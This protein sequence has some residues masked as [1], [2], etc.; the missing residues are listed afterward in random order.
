[1]TPQVTSP[2]D[3]ATTVFY[4]CFVD[5]HRLSCTVST[6][7]AL[8][9]VPKNGGKTISAARGACYTGSEATVRFLDLDLEYVGF[10][11]FRLSFTCQK[12]FDFFDLNVKCPLKFL[13]KEHSSVEN[14]SSMKP[15]K[16][17]L[18]VTLR[19]LRHSACKSVHWPGL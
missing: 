15:Q 18:W 5:I 3:R 14:F 19:R 7:L 17:L 11:I 12:L 6:L 10:I 13:E 4:S 16:T 8:F 2:V 1:L 9:L